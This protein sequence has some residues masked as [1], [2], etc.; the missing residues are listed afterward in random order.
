MLLSI[1]NETSA[2][3]CASRSGRPKTG[4]KRRPA[5][6]PSPVLNALE[7]KYQETLGSIKELKEAEYEWVG[8]DGY[9]LAEQWYRQRLFALEGMLANIETTSR[10]FDP[11]W[12]R[13][14]L[15]VPI[16]PRTSRPLLDKNEFRTAFYAVV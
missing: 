8:R 15:M 14:A 6:N 10:A 7:R 11:L 9:D 2:D 16:I 3:R 12:K 1:E 13:K 4:R 5:T